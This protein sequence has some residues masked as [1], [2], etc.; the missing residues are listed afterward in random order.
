MS[1]GLIAV[2]LVLS[3]GLAGCGFMPG[4]APGLYAT[5]WK[6][7]LVAGRQ[8]LAGREPT[9][10]F[11]RDTLTGSGGCNHLSGKYKVEGDRIAITELGA[12]LA[13]CPAPAGEIEGLFLN[14]LARAEAFRSDGGNLVITGAGGE[15]GLRP[16]P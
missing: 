6:A 15:I 11:A 3:I 2:S 1:R 12:N 8:P 9:L 7:V 10:K 5:E 16:D 14:A 4:A 13:G